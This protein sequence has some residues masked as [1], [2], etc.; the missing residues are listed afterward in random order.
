MSREP[1][2]EEKAEVIREGMRGRKQRADLILATV[3][4]QLKPRYFLAWE[5]EQDVP[6]F[7][8]SGR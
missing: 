1:Q 5:Q 4:S 2:G 8:H 3:D 7:P 6:V